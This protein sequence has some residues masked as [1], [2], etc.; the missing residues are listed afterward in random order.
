M[1][2]LLSVAFVSLSMTC[3]LFNIEQCS[4]TVYR[5]ERYI[6]S[7][8]WRNRRSTYRLA[9]RETG[10]NRRWQPVQS[11]SELVRHPRHA[12]SRLPRLDAVGPIGALFGRRVHG[13]AARPTR[14]G[15]P[16]NLRLAVCLLV[17]DTACSRPDGTT[18]QRTAASGRDRAT[19]PTSTVACIASVSGR[20]LR[21]SGW[22]IEDHLPPVR[23]V[24]QRRSC[25]FDAA[26]AVGKGTIDDRLAW[27][28]QVVDEQTKLS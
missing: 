21:D 28:R 23:R 5:T 9:S 14:Q 11:L 26:D 2:T 19:G 13:T 27:H 6:S 12:A 7:R 3:R 15:A 4:R 17:S 24:V 25:R 10:V 8:A 22:V 20:V 1:K 16:R 18:D